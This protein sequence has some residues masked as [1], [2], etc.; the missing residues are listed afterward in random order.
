MTELTNHPRIEMVPR[1]SLHPN[2]KNPRKHSDKQLHQIGGSIKRF[3]FV[4]P[5]IADDASLIVAGAGRW[6]A[7]GLIGLT[8]VPVIR[9]RFMTEADRRAFALAENRLGDLSE[10]DDALLSA[11]LE[12]LYEQDYDLGLTGFSLG[13]F[14]VQLGAEPATAQ[15]PV[16]LPDPTG[17]AVSRP[18]DLWSVGPH[19]LYCG[20]ARD[21]ASYEALLGADRATMV[22]ADP[23]YN[24][25]IAGNVSGLGQVQ[26]REFA[27]AS[28]EMTSPEFT[29]FLRT[30]FRHCVGFSGNGSIHYHCMDW[31]HVRE[32]MD[33]S[34]GVYTTFKQLAVWVK[35]NAGMGTFYRSQHELVFIFKSGNERHINSFGLG[36]K[37]R[38][39]T[40]VWSFAGANT[41]RKGRAQDLADHPTVKPVAMVADAIL[42]CSHRGDLILDPFSGSG[43]TLIAAHRTKRVGAGLELDPLYVDTALRRLGEATGHT[44]V[45]GDGR[46]WNEVATER[47]AEEVSRG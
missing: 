30:V 25:P 41:F 13:D 3:G 14:D 39:R 10:W 20:N 27:E 12:F 40:N 15:E 36:E 29:S 8:E 23:P 17:V 34:D 1:T 43:T 22:F 6:A 38:Y 5:I 9:A 11:E 28:G 19:R 31:R 24:V 26:H 35:D 47:R 46:S 33:A 16:E 21:R 42:D 45:L 18:G 44:P 4:V 32:M 2:P 7:A 37:G